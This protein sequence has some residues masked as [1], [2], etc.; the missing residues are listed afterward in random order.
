MKTIK[1]VRIGLGKDRD[2]FRKGLGRE[3]KRE[4]ALVLVRMDNARFNSAKVQ[5]AYAKLRKEK[6]QIDFLKCH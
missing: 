2:V 3:I 1:E 6:P 5:L 4:D